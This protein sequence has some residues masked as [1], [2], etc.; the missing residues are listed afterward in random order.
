MNWKHVFAVEHE[1]TGIILTH[2]E[3]LRFV[4][5]PKKKLRKALEVEL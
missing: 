2:S 5:D 4:T 1:S 3:W